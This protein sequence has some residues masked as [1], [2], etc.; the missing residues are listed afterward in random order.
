VKVSSGSGDELRWFNKEFLHII[1]LD[2]NEESEVN[3]IT[4]G[5]I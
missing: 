3:R 4:N 1:S 5:G 2:Q